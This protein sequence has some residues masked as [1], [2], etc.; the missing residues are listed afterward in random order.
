[1]LLLLTLILFVVAFAALNR[2]AGA[3]RWWTGNGRNIYYV[4]PLAALATFL[5]TG[6]H[7]V[8]ALTVAVAWAVYRLPGWYSLNDM[9]RNNPEYW[10]DPQSAVARDFILMVLRQSWYAIPLTVVGAF[11]GVSLYIGIPLVFLTGVLGAY[12]YLIGHFAWVRDNDRDPTVYAEFAAGAFL[13][14]I[15]WVFV[16]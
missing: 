11:H 6:G 9:G 3:D 14:L 12:G 2:S 4:I 7:I 15:T 1:M 5:F 13:G 10:N 16:T 8:W